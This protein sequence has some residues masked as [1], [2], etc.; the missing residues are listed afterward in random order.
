[1][2]GIKLTRGM[3]IDILNMFEEML[4]AKRITIPDDDRAGDEDEARL[5]GATYAKLEDEITYYLDVFI[6]EEE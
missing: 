3:A 4:E 6:K 5:Y 1:M 2:N